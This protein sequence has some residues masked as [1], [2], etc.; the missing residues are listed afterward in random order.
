MLRIYLEYKPVAFVF[1]H[2]Y[3]VL[4]ENTNVVADANGGQVIRGDNQGTL[5]VVIKQIG[6]SEDAYSS[7]FPFLYAR[8]SPSC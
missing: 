8:R 4:R 6:L 3:L 7:V 2:L 5:D 1:N